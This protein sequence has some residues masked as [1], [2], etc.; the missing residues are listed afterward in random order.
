M[1]PLSSSLLSFWDT[2]RRQLKGS[3]E[4]QDG[5]FFINWLQ[6][7]QYQEATRMSMDV[8]EER[9]TAKAPAAIAWRVCQGRR[10]EKNTHSPL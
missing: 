7:Q 3:Q 1:E 10:D 4:N 8:E 5:L 2:R 9:Q 6:E